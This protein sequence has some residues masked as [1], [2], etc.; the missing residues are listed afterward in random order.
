MNEMI[1]SLK[2][3]E[4]LLSTR[5]ICVTVVYIVNDFICFLYTRSED[6]QPTSMERLS[7][8]GLTVSSSGGGGGGSVPPSPR[9]SQSMP[10]SPRAGPL[11]STFSSPRN[12]PQASPRPGPPG[13]FASPRPAGPSLPRPGGPNGQAPQRPAASGPLLNSRLSGGY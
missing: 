5:I 9:T 1:Y 6:R 4:L 3:H 13:G 2:L 10:S 11:A 8:L 12:G 7:A